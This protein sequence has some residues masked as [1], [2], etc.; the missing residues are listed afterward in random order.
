[1]KQVTNDLTYTVK[2]KRGEIIK[3]CILMTAV[4]DESMDNYE[5]FIRIRDELRQQYMAEDFK[6][7]KEV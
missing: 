2:L 1:M 4:L 5:Y 3:L 6:R 7:L